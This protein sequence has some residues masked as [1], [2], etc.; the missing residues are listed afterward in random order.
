MVHGL[1]PQNAHGYPS[2]CDAAGRVPSRT[3]IDD[4]TTIYPDAAL[5]RHEWRMHGACTG[6]SPTDY[7][8]AVRLA[9]R[10]IRIPPAFESPHD[11]RTWQPLE[12]ARAFTAA[13]PRLRTDTMGVTCRA[14]ML[15]EVRLCLSKDLRDFVSC[16]E[17]ARASCRRPIQVPPV[18]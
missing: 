18:L 15:E 6:L 3:A 9:R 13:N 10:S 1:W 12:I 4:A 7:F 8:A 2:N 11:Q 16:P 14:D 5:A 17:V